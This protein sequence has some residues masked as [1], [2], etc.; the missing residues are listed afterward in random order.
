MNDDESK[1][2][3]STILLS[4]SLPIIWTD[5]FNCL[6]YQLALTH[7]WFSTKINTNAAECVLC[8]SAL[9]FFHIFD[10]FQ[11]FFSSKKKDHWMRIFATT[12]ISI[13]WRC[14]FHCAIT[15]SIDIDFACIKCGRYCCCSYWWCFCS[16]V[17]FSFFRW[18]P[19]KSLNWKRMCLYFV[20]VC[21]WIF[22]T[23]E[24]NHAYL[25]PFQC[26]VLIQLYK[27]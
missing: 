10:R 27:M 14:C 3:F 22:A 6:L 8:I 1:V 4:L 5:L 9:L 18:W 20:C 2:L 19:L 23:K 26:C 12:T 21:E 17:G 7:A 15:Y 13:V 16:F 24:S 11:Y 25:Y